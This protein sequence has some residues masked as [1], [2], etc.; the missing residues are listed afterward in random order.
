MALF[1]HCHKVR[2]QSVPPQKRTEPMGR[3]SFRAD[4]KAAVV[5][6]SG[7][8]LSG[9]TGV[10]LGALTFADGYRDAE[11]NR[12][13]G[14]SMMGLGFLGALA[15]ALMMS[16]Y[17][18]PVAIILLI[19]AAITTVVVAWF[20]PDGVQRWLDKTIHFGGNESGRF[21]DLE[22]QNAALRALRG[23]EGA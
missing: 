18:I 13:Y 11:L 23:G 2:T 4:T 10:V 8:W 5:K 15:S 3:W 7:R 19:V 20:K 22:S 6:A 1:S 9:V 21:A 16:G 17:G 14:I 12:V